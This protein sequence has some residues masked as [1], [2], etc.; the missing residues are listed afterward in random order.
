MLD[1]STLP[2]GPSALRNVHAEPVVLPA[3]PATSTPFQ[4]DK[5][6]HLMFGTVG[7]LQF[8]IKDLHRRGYADPNEWSQPLPTGLVDLV[9]TP[10]HIGLAQWGFAG[11]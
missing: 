6:R 8:T 1:T 11:F 4:P 10:K 3:T 9:G 7:A 5:V 2:V